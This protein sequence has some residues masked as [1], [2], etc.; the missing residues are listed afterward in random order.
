MPR[1]GCFAWSVQ[2]SA[3]AGNIDEGFQIL[4]FYSTVRFFSGKPDIFQSYQKKLLFESNSSRIVKVC[5]KEAHTS[6][7]PAISSSSSGMIPRCSQG[8]QEIYLSSM[9]SCLYPWSHFFGHYPQFMTTGVD[10]A[11]FSCSHI[12]ISYQWVTNL[13]LTRLKAWRLA[14]RAEN[15]VVGKWN[16]LCRVVTSKWITC[17]WNT[18]N[19]ISSSSFECTVRK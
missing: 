16:S 18:R 4:G 17:Q 1:K 13:P 9:F 12:M 8:N 11:S 6:F 5:S 10:D 19:I 3:L 14:R 2:D 15:C 7:S